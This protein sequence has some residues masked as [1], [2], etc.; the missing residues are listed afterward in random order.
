MMTP[1]E[2][3]EYHHRTKLWTPG[4]PPAVLRLLRLAM[5][6]ATETERERCAAIA[7][8]HTAT[9]GISEVVRGDDETAREIAARI[10]SA[11]CVQSN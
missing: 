3:F 7:D 4:D 10:R 1:E 5:A 2:W 6:D 9:R 8:R 11:P